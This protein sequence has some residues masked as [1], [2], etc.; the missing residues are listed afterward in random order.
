MRGL[1][2]KMQRVFTQVNEVMRQAGGGKVSKSEL[3][4]LL[5]EFGAILMAIPDELIKIIVPD[6]MSEGAD[7][8]AAPTKAV[9][10]VT[11]AGDGPGKSSQAELVSLR[12]QL[13]A[14]ILYTKELEEQ[15]KVLTE[16]NTLLRDQVK[17]ATTLTSAAPPL[18]LG[19]PPAAPSPKPARGP[20]A[21]P[22]PPPP[23]PL[24]PP[25][26]PPPPPPSNAAGG[27]EAR[28]DGGEGGRGDLLAAIQGG[29]GG[30]K[31]VVAG[32]TGDDSAPGKPVDVRSQL[33]DAIANG[34][35]KLKRVDPES[36]LANVATEPA[37][38]GNNVANILASALLQRREKMKGDGD[39][40]ESDNSDS[41]SDSG[42][43]D[44]SD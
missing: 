23:P 19:A 26:P 30:L 21:P 14:S 8:G 13:E 22:A 35:T 9:L 17:K 31:K 20:P 33:M 7:G 4:Y 29:G 6:A 1:D 2:P 42:S 25:P 38:G 15:V 37:S 3:K 24:P 43:E 40:N 27:R 36:N 11:D 5:N 32:G 39:S 18:P 41:D 28:G 12:Q 44:W 16:Q 34:A 10:T